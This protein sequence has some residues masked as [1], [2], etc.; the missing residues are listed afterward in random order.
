M[1][2]QY[3]YIYIYDIQPFV[4]YIFLTRSSSDNNMHHTQLLDPLTEKTQYRFLKK[5]LTHRIFQRHL[6]P[7]RRQLFIIFLTD[8]GHLLNN[9]WQYLSIT[10]TLSSGICRIY[11]Q[12]NNIQCISCYRFVP[13]VLVNLQS[14]YFPSNKTK[15]LS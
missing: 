8:L 12:Q 2:M 11:A 15:G 14:I 13:S 5:H 6:T 1:T 9:K 7:G 4:I 3:I 10:Q